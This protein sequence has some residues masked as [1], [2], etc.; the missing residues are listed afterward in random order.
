MNVL[1]DRGTCKK[2]LKDAQ[3]E[4]ME[5]FI[6]KNRYHV[7][8]CEEEDPMVQKSF[9]NSQWPTISRKWPCIVFL[10]HNCREDSKTKEDQIMSQRVRLLEE[11]AS[12]TSKQLEV[13]TEL[14]SEKQLVLPT[15]GKSFADAASKKE[16]APSLIIVDKPDQ[17]PS[18]SER[19]SKMEEFKQVAIQS[20]ASIKRAFTNKS[21]K[22]VFLCNNEKSKDIMLPQVKKLF[23]T[24]KVNTPAPKLPTISVPFIDGQYDKVELLAAMK[25]QNE[26][27]GI[28]FDD[29]NTQ[30]IFT[31]P[32]KDQRN[33][34]L[35]Q[36]VIRVS[37]DIRAKIKANGNR[38]FIGSSSCPVYDRFYVKRC[39]NCQTFHHFHKDCLKPQVCAN[40]SGHHDTR[41]CNKENGDYKCINCAIGG[42]EDTSHKASSIDCPAY[43]A[44]QEKLRKSIFYYSKN[45]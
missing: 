21:G 40:C 16:D 42:F 34:G 20:K 5:C 15:P 36:A 9:L 25:N 39:N 30:V 11:S 38:I 1:D 37:D 22:T 14:L 6:C 23:P 3:N 26:E 41:K 33:E 17:E 10:C 29:S 45:S 31:S 44:E 7:I 32:M 2:C 8:E 35:Y 18:E 43:I 13:I 4:H 19:K 27:N 12:K 24:S 28:N